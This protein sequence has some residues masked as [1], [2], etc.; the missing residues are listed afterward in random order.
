MGEHLAGVLDERG[1][2]PV[3]DRREVDL[4]AAA[5][6]PAAQQV[7]L[8]VARREGGSLA[9]ADGALARGGATRGCGRAARP[10]PNG[11]AT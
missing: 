2:Q 5:R 1:E 4:R 8:E 10:T 9:V 3:L 6:H 7:D 11:L